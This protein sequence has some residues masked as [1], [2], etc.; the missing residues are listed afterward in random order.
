MLNAENAAGLIKMYL[1]ARTAYGFSVAAI[2]LMEL[3]PSIQV[4]VKSL[5]AYSLDD[6]FVQG[7]VADWV[8]YNLEAVDQKVLFTIAVL[9][10]DG[11]RPEDN[12]DAVL[13]GRKI[14][15]GIRHRHHNRL[16]SNEPM[17]TSA[18]ID[19]RNQ[20][21]LPEVPHENLLRRLQQVV[22]PSCAV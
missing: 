18:T 5:L 17:F 15:C 20:A 10:T 1:L 22:L 13:Y 19:R 11:L 4:R 8:A 3:K 9:A 21:E 7:R 12:L 2:K 14:P 16:H 6:M